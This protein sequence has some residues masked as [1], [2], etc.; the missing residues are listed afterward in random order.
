MRSLA[1]V[2]LALLAAC[3]TPPPVVAVAPPL[4][5][6]PSVRARILAIAEAEWRE[7]GA[8]DRQVGE[9]AP[10]AS[11]EAQVEN[12]PRV[13]A[14]W[15]VAPDEDGTI[16]SN[17]RIYAAA[18]A[19]QPEGARLW[20]AQAWSA[21]F[22]SYVFQRAGVDAREFRPTAAHSF[23]ID[24]MLKDA[25]DFPAQAPFF[26]RSP[27]E[28]APQPGDLVCADRSRNGIS[29]W[30]QR[31]ADNGAF[32]PMHCDLVVAVTPQGVEAIGGNVAD[33]VA[34]TRSPSE[35]APQP[36]DLVCA[37][38]SRNGISDWRQRAADNGAF[39][40][41]HCD[42]VVAVT[43]QGVEAI[44][45][46]VADTVARTRFPIDAGGLLLPYPP[47]GATWFGVFENRLGRLGPWAPRS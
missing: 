20:R 7:W 45:G 21:A 6:P 4:P 33:T 47:G 17:R 32:R 43:P 35:Y 36:G 30:R 37:D 44:G 14:Y 39:R 18:L 3:A 16:A 9:A 1:L 13:L 40:P 29:D 12:F 38:R 27:S 31:A 23:Y 11:A 41:M 24:H 10:A 26:P 28:Y 25:A 46:N 22:I 42:L 2:L 5:Y 34:R 15:L 19:G 8:L